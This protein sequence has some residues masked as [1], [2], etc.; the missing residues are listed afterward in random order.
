MILVFYF[1]VTASSQYLLIDSMTQE[2]GK[3]HLKYNSLIKAKSYNMYPV[4]LLLAFSCH[5][6]Y[7]LEE[8]EAS[9]T[10]CLYDVL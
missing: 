8:E 5:S 3:I 2:L 10:D 1:Y 6:V 7:S 4:L 9:R